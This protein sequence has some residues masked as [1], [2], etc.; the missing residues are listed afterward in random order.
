MAIQMRR[1]NEAD[2]KPSRMVPAEF[3][4]AVDIQKAHIAFAPG[5]SKTLMTE[6]DAAD[7]IDKAASKTAKESEAWAHG[8]SFEK[9]VYHSETF[10]GNSSDK[11]FKL[12]NVPDSVKKV[13]LN[14]Y[15]T[16]A[17]T[18]LDD[19]ITFVNTP[20]S[21]TTIQVNYTTH[22]T[23]DTSKDNSKYYSEQAQASAN[24][25]S[26]KAKVVVDNADKIDVIDKNIK[27]VN[28]VSANISNVNTVSTNITNVNT[29][30][31]N[32]KDINTVVKDISNVNI[33]A[34]NIKD[35]NTVA[36]DI[37]D[38]NTVAKGIISVSTAATNITD[39]NTA[40]TNIETIKKAPDC[41]SDAE[42]WAV[43]QRDGKD[44]LNADETFENNSKWYAEHSK[45][46]AVGDTGIRTGENTDNSKY[47]SEQ[48]SDSADKAKQ[49]EQACLKLS[50]II[51]P[52]FHIDP[53]DLHLIQDGISEDLSFSINNYGHLLVTM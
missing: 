42:A 44:V 3:G 18:L 29:A 30:A 50:K 13:L 17:Y 12:A 19:T 25:A 31:A 22:K 14:G 52:K 40:A 27:A 21:G 46:Y 51:M 4:I 32:I 11:S 33:T 48:A 45:S 20:A 7:M 16:T 35:V 1:G 8:N 38:V 24:T 6:E 26:E 47:Y 37:K 10:T 34:K 28:T 43:G 53:D 9:D 15:T 36:A 23:V 2:Y 39:I 49:S 5:Q 41:A